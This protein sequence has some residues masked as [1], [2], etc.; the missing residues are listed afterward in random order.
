MLFTSIPLIMQCANGHMMCKPCHTKLL[1]DAN[2]TRSTPKCPV[3]QD[4]ERCTRNLVAES[5]V[6]ELMTQ[7]SACNQELTRG[8]LAEHVI[9]YCS[10]R[11]RVYGIYFSYLIFLTCFADHK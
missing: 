10:K 8:Q 3:C 2:V 5:T 11:Y 7:C 6:A 9:G 1:A 4:C